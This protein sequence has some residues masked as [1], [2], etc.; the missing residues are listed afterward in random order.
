MRSELYFRKILYLILITFLAR[1]ILAFTL[2]LGNDEAYYFTYALQ[3]D[4]NH[5][6]HPPLVGIF[7]RLFTFNLHWVNDFSMRLPAILSASV[8]TWLIFKCGKILKDERTGWIAAVLY[9]TSVYASIISGFFILPDS[10]QSVFWLS[11]I[12]FALKLITG[13]HSKKETNTLLILIGITVGLA[14]MCKIHGVF[15]WFGIIMYMLIYDRSFFKNYFLYIS[16]LITCM[17]IS[18]ILIWNIQ[19]HFVTWRFNSQR[20]EVRHFAFNTS[21]FFAALGGQIAYNNPV[22]LIIYALALPGIRKMVHPKGAVRLLKW[23]SFPIILMVTGISMFRDV[24][25]HWS[26][27]GFT[28]LILLGSFVISENVGKP[29]GLKF[30]RWI[31]AAVVL[32]IS[33]VLIGVSMVKFYPGTLGSKQVSQL[34]SSDVTLDMVGWHQLSRVFNEI[35]DDELNR[36]EASPTDPIL[37]NK[38]FPGG[39]I[40]L[41]VAF[42]SNIRVV[43]AGDLFD[44]HKFAWLNRQEGYLAKGENAYFITASNNYFDP[45]V[46]YKGQ[47]ENIKL[48][49]QFPEYRSGVRVRTWYVYKLENALKPLGYILDK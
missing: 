29:G 13:I 8:S 9:N 32:I 15:L 46:V 45:Y 14:T 49:K 47:F 22:N 7:I 48:L 3:P 5:F 6:D 4:W 27:P 30:K 36:G 37:V 28:G 42:P 31:A 25:P 11:G 40:L 41:Y 39:H 44:I 24:L 34:G 33:F 16:L 23:L 20:V 17:I 10:P 18:P 19:N 26:G 21:G 1:C 2:D 38:W 12:Y 43:G 35:R